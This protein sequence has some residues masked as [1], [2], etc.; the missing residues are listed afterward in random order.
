MTQQV[1]T[2]VQNALYHRL[3]RVMN[4]YIKE[5]LHWWRSTHQILIIIITLLDVNCCQEHVKQL[6]W[7]YVSFLT[8]GSFL[9]S[10]M[11]K[12]ERC[13]DVKKGPRK[14]LSHEMEQNDFTLSCTQ[15][16][17]C[18]FKLTPSVKQMIAF[19]KQPQYDRGSEQT[20]SFSMHSQLKIDLS[21]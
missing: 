15:S 19:S 17:L 13:W 4:V 9:R 11:R 7:V 8:W 18:R 1:C 2:S 20:A 6:E 16:M 21:V 3:L 5:A 14:Q 12:S 10:E